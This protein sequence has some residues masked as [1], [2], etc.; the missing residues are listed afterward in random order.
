MKLRAPLVKTGQRLTAE[1][2]NQTARAI[3]QGLATPRDLEQGITE[4]EAETGGKTSLVEIS[5]TT[6]TERVFDPADETVYVDVA[7]ITSITTLN[8]STGETV[9]TTF[10]DS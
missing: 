9:T 8:Q 3:N 2:W 4:A 6:T 1:L 10:S 7:R 5:R